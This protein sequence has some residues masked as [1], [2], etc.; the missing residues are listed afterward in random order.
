MV[1]KTRKVVIPLDFDFRFSILEREEERKRCE[2]EELME[3]EKEER[4]KFYRARGEL[5]NFFYQQMVE[6]RAAKGK[7]STSVQK[8]RLQ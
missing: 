5:R 3:R 7:N 4:R 8:K 1:E 2:K 6:K